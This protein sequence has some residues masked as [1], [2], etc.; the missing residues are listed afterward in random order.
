M[1]KNTLHS[2]TTEKDSLDYIKKGSKT[3]KLDRELLFKIS[4]GTLD[5]SNNA[6]NFMLYTINY[7][8]KDGRIYCDADTIR[9]QLYF[10]N[11]TYRRVVN[12]LK[13]LN[14]IYE[15][16]EF[17]YSKFHVLSNGDKNDPS[18]VRNL[19]VLTS[20]DI[21]SLNK[22]KKRFFLYVASFASVGTIKAV[23]V[24]ALYSNKYHSGVNYIESYL[25]LAE[26]LIS[27][28]KGGYLVVFINGKRY[29]EKSV[30][31]ET[32]LHTYCGYD[33]ETR[34]K[35]MS[36]TREHKIGLKIHEQFL[37]NVAPNESSKAEFHYFA[38]KYHIYY[39]VM[40]AKTI[41]LFINIQNELFNLFGTV[42]VEVYRQALTSYF[43]K[44]QE[45][46][47][48][49]DLLV[50]ENDTKAVNTM[51][52]FYLIKD[53]EQIITNVLSKEMADSNIE[54]YFMDTEELAKLVSYFI[55]VSS[56]DHK[57]MLEEKLEQYG[58]EL[59]LLAQSIPQQNI[60]E[61]Q[62]L[63]L[64][65]HITAIYEQ[66]DFNMGKLPSDYKKRTIRK[67]ASEGILTRK[68]VLKQT[69]Q[70]LKDKILFMPKREKI[71]LSPRI[72]QPR[73]VTQSSSSSS[74]MVPSD[75]YY[76]WLDHK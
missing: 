24:E 69:I 35:R 28:V 9:N 44:E 20:P 13:L 73:V 17:L 57:I 72:E 43:K 18:Y 51:M 62:W 11:K 1:M 8:A 22:T 38:D 41:P 12:E 2:K 26:I 16:N 19:E 40:R 70:K 68:E 58:F 32:Q 64:S 25:S 5:V 47:L 75:V 52:D 50:D 14:L 46:V 48:Y 59:N 39:E 66:L 23:S 37:N 56:D 65:N 27:F 54:Q 60:L 74:R 49:H 15:E 76:N 61:N 55:E 10:Q 31:F 67:W 33:F 71:L 4:N 7:V 29:D 34:K 53:L 30:D 6:I 3:A 42:G 45:N 36:K 63:K 21:L